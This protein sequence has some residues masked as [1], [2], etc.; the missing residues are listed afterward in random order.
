MDKVK[1]AWRYF[2]TTIVLVFTG[3]H[4][5]A[6]LSI[7]DV[8][9]INGNYHFSYTQTPEKLVP[10]YPLFTG[11]SYQW[12]QSITPLNDFTTIAGA[13]S[14]DYTFTSPLTQ[15]T[16]FRRKITLATGANFYSNSIKIEL[17][18][19]NWENQNYV[20][21]HS[22]LVSAVT[23]WQAVDQLPIGQKLQT[24]TYLDGLGRAIQSVSKETATPNA[25]QPN[26]WGDMVQFYK[27]DALGRQPLQYL[28][29]TTATEPGK[30]KTTA[31]TEQ[32]QYY[33]TVYNETSAFN[34][35]T[36]DNSP[37]N[38]VFNTKSAGTSWAASAGNSALYDLNSASDNVRIFSVGYN[39]GDAPVSSGTYAANTLIKIT[40]TDENG[41]SVIEFTDKN[42]Q[43][44]LTKT[45][46]DDNPSPTSHSGWICVY[47]IYDDFGLLRYR[48]QPEGVKWLEPNGWSFSGTDGQKVLAEQCFRYEYDEQG[49]NTLKKAPGAKELLMIYDQRDRVVFMQDGNQRLKSP[50][51]WTA[52]LYDELDRPVI[53]TL[54]H[55]NKTVAALQADI[56]NAVTISTVTVTNQATPLINLV[57]N[58]R[59]QSINLYTAQSG[60]EFTP[61]FESAGNDAFTAEINGSATSQ[62]VTVTTATY[63]NP[64]TQS[65]LNNN[66]VS[67]ILK[68]FFYDNYTFSSVKSFDN[69]FD[70]GLAYSNGDP[71]APSERTINM[72][73]GTMTRVLGTSTFLTSTIYYDDEGRSI[74]SIEDNIKAGIDITT[75]QY[76]FDGRVL[77]TNT[78]HSAAGSGYYSFSTVTKNL[79][80]KIGRVN[81]IQKKFGAN[82]F[83]TIAEYAFDDMGRLKTKRLDPGYTGSGKNELESLEYSY[84]INDEITGI[85]KDYALKTPGKYSKWGNFFGLYIGYDNRDGVF[86]NAQLDGHVT[87]TLWTTMGD[88]AQRKYDFTYDNAGRLINALFKEKQNPGDAW[89]STKMDFSVTGRNG[90]IEY[91][92]NGNL[93]YMLHKGVLPG[94]PTPVT[95]DD[96][97]YTYASFSNKLLKVT[98]NGNLGATNGKLGD[99]TDGTNATNDDY[100]YDDNG[101][102]VIDLNKNAKDLNNVTGANGIRYNHLDKPE[103]IRIV[104]KGVIKFVYDADGTRLQKLY[105]AEGS[106]TTTTTT[107]INEFVYQDDNLQ[108]FNFEEGRVRLLQ[109]V[110][111]NNGYDFL[112]IEGNMDLPGGKRGAY[113]FFIRDYLGNVRMILTEE[114]HAGSNACTM[115]T[116]RAAN[117]EPLFGQVDA[118][119]NP[120][121]GNEVQARFPV[122]NI[123]GQSGGNGWQNATIG[124]HVSRIGNLT[125]KKIGPNTLLKVMAGD[126]VSATTIY[127]Y[128][129]PVVNQAGGTSLIS[130]LLLSLTQAIT[131]SNITSAIT[132]GAASNIT[133][134]LGGSTPFTSIANPDANNANGN[135]PKAYLSVLFFDERFNFVSEGSASVR[136]SSSGNGAPALVLANIKAPKNGYAYV[137]VS[138]QSDEMVYFDNLQVAN[139]RGRIAEE[140][141]FYAYGLKVAAISS[142]K[143]PDA[144]E[145]HLTNKDLYNDKELI[146]EADLNWYDYGFR[147]YDPQIGR[148]PQLDPLTDD[149]PYYTPYQFAGCEPIANVDVDGLEPAK[150]IE[151]AKS[152][153]GSSILQTKSGWGVLSNAN[154]AWT[155]TRFS[156]A[157]ATQ[158]ASNSTRLWGLLKGL[159]GLVEAGVGAVG[160]IVTSWTGVGAI[161]GGAAVL[162]GSDVAASGFTQLWTG[163]ETQSF[164]EQGIS[165]GLEALGVSPDN[166]GTIAG[167]ADGGISIGLSAGAGT[168]RNAP[169]LTKKPPSPQRPTSVFRGGEKGKL[170][171]L[172][173]ILERNHL[174]TMDGLRKAG[175]KISEKQGSAIQMLYKE[176]RD[177]ISTGS[178][179]ASKAFRQIEANLLRQ[180]KFMEAFELNANRL[181]STYGN[182][183]KAAIDEARQYFQDEI[184]PILSGQLK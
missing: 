18:S 175:F 24:T 23:T 62:P 35:I 16:W 184:I 63:T 94:N 126:Q 139:N 177:F 67:T 25:A 66:S 119:G 41:K 21:N 70:N 100:V 87:G 65:D 17:V 11:S 60:I 168:A 69:N 144:N 179:E 165:N 163:K 36:F 91:D 61:G 8:A 82:D 53:T 128:K 110:A 117:E 147:Y 45:Q 15:T 79:F 105:T 120:V 72:V 14:A 40:H 13:T 140:N 136:V 56:N 80:D 1:S 180:G 164:T 121:S 84:N 7:F 51:E 26:L 172:K 31:L 158:T 49:R 150:A 58:I 152:M 3:F 127:Y 6:Q 145:G 176:H 75:L 77:S 59:Q 159:G 20:R 103:E 129:D 98:D 71:I 2:F 10:L 44:I 48:I 4:S 155:F 97:Q 88:D 146:D 46:I 112:T 68:Y 99:F 50:A 39:T 57:V 33:T 124:N 38:R 9:P 113:D 54:Y 132:K 151:F 170:L 104:G 73:T 116:Q 22:V 125:G 154:G 118:N 156:A 115:E 183:Y 78:K 32:P 93:Q 81:G 182:K 85:N 149:Y 157:A 89:S 90:K 74:Q 160:G 42:G 109:P 137:Y 181:L 142:H 111:Q 34:S 169:L 107:Y 143:L 178:S 162:H 131:G 92:L 47:S 122:A 55:T 12:E 173:K 29:Y 135:N 76:Q 167:Y 148:F 102:L 174:P 28:P 141:H 101:N 153:P 134:Q 83:K 138:N 5:F 130:D 43:L 133:T 123:P 19:A 52:N 166:A 108:Y 96:L 27:Y 106:T 37:L 161:A 30:F 95:V 171:A 86:A 64:I 114:T